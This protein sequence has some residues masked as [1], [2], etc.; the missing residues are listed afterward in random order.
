[1]SGQLAAI[2]WRS[3]RQAALAAARLPGDGFVTINVS[4]RLFRGGDFDA[5]LP[6]M[7]QEP[8]VDPPLLRLELAASELHEDTGSVAA[9]R[10]RRRDGGVEGAL[11]DFGT[12]ASSLAYV[13][14]FPLR[15][16]KI[17][18]SFVAR[19]DGEQA[20]RSRAV[21]AAMVALA[22]ALEL[23]VLAVGVETEAQR[24]ALL[25]MGCR[26]GQGYLFGRA[27]PLA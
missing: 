6:G 3:F 17:D 26:L 16:V 25:A 9:A 15:M 23:E 7:L 10:P 21:L 5:R 24:D 18:R 8:R 4:P 19:L 14:R 27:Q 12:G 20:G 1:D 2:D 22:H 11:D 13:H